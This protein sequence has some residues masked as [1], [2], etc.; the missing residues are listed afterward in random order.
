MCL[1]ARPLRHCKAQCWR[2]E[3]AVDT[4]RR[5]PTTVIAFRHSTL[6]VTRVSSVG[7]FSELAALRC[8]TGEL[9]RFM[10]RSVSINLECNTCWRRATLQLESCVFSF[11][12][13]WLQHPRVSRSLCEMQIRSADQ[14]RQR[15]FQR[16]H[17]VP[18]ALC[19]QHPKWHGRDW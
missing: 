4:H 7:L 18:R 12:S 17:T 6:S 5:Q 1:S 16:G 15:K 13:C 2:A 14:P 19:C 10:F 8:Y 9:P 11:G 3:A